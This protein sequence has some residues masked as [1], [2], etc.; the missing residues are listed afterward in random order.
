[1]NLRLVAKYL[2]Y[3]CLAT[4]VFMLPAAAWAAYFGEWRAFVAFMVS[5]GIAAGV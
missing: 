2:G 1:M 5:L 3:F 4:G